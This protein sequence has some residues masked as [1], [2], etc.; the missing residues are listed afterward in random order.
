MKLRL[1]LATAPQPN[2]RPFM[3]GAVL[4]GA[5]GLIAF[6][7][8]SHAAY[9]SWRSTRDLRAQVARVEATMQADR[10]RQQSLEQY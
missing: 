4:T 3:V 10:Q 7:I 6:A 9:A 1:N 2:N 5:I 8:L